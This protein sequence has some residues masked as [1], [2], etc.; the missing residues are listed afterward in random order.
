MLWQLA[1][2]RQPLRTV[3][4]CDGWKLNLS[5]TDQCEIYDLNTDPY[6]QQNLFDDPSQSAR[7]RDLTARI[8]LWQ[9]R[10]GDAALLPAPS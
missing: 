4:S 10:T 9:H 1:T 7:I 8:R 6:E 2:N 3:I 5:A